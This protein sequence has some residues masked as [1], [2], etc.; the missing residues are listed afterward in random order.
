MK[1]RKSGT[2]WPDKDEAN[3][4][5]GC[6]LGLA[7]GDAVGASVEFK[8]RGSFSPMIDMVGGGPHRLE[9]GQWTDDTSMA[10]CL[11]TS[12]VERGGFDADD[13]MHRYCR[14]RGQGYLSSTDKCF[15]IGKRQVTHWTVF[16][17]PVRHWLGRPIRNSLRTVR[18]CDLLR[19]LISC[20]EI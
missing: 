19:C 14:W 12:L 16:K 11:A 1:V 4:F 20:A 2:P 17:P 18:S 9:P 6:L 13:Q 15:D 10:L 5:L 7:V 8:K 3:R